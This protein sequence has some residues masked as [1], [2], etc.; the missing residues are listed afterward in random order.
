MIEVNK[1]Y[2]VTIIDL[3]YKGDGIAKI[4]D[5]FIYVQGLLKDETAII[6]IT[7]AKNNIAFGK[8]IKILKES[9]DRI[10]PN[11]KLGSDN[12]SH[13]SFSKQLEWQK[14]I[15]KKTLEKVL[16]KEINVLETITDNNEYNY[17]NKVT[18]HVFEDKTLKL[19]LYKKGSKDLVIVNDFILTHNY[20]NKIVNKINDANLKVDSRSLKHIIFKN[21]SKNEVLITLVSFKEYFFGREKLIELLKETNNLVGIVLNI[22]ENN[23][24]ILGSKS[25][26]LYKDNYLEEGIFYITDKS[27]FQVNFGVAKITNEIIKSFIKGND[28]IDAYSGIGNIG[29]NILDIN[30]NI[31]MIDNNSENI[32]LATKIKDENNYNNVELVLGNSETVIKEFNATTL[33]VDPPRAG[34]H[35]TFINEILNKEIERII[36]LS[37]DLQSLARD[38]R[39]LDSKYNIINVY[40][41]KMFP[42]TN[43]FETLVIL[44]SNTLHI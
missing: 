35:N 8:V 9:K 19:G 25:I 26:T 6:K 40:P 38:L 32:D 13:L 28:I 30:K 29:Y 3:D 23:N 16:K 44:E 41:I 37:C 5:F 14:D 18:Y 2:E 1:E 4:G 12:L 22:K 27:F 20:I 7:K 10:K 31:T 42:Q 33:I 39:L 17:R 34:L 21:N 43:S 15:T 36:Y 11:S 24:E